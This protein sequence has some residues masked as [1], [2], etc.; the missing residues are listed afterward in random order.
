MLNTTFLTVGARLEG[1]MSRVDE[2]LRQVKTDEET[3][4][5]S[6][7]LNILELTKMQYKL[8][9]AVTWRYT[10][11][12]LETHQFPRL[13]FYAGSLLDDL[14][15]LLSRVAK[16]HL[17]GDNGETFSSAVDFVNVSKRFMNFFEKVSERRVNR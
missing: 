9:K 13:C 11:P 14:N 17:V 1:L 16:C 4:A 10:H 5:C 8:L 7:A 3:L 12:P 6:R 2:T 15:D